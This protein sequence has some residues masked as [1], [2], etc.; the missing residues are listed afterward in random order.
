MLHV[1]V[2]RPNIS[3]NINFPGKRSK[4]Y[5]LRNKCIDRGC[6]GLFRAGFTM[7]FLRSISRY[8]SSTHQFLRYTCRNQQKNEKEHISNIKR[9]FEQDCFRYKSTRIKHSETVTTFLGTIKSITRL[10]TNICQ[11]AIQH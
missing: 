5:H 9:N 4:F 11:P 2:T 10:S 1:H 7:P 3:K 6:F 8:I